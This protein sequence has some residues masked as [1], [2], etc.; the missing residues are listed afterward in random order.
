MGYV[1][2]EAEPIGPVRKLKDLCNS[3]GEWQLARSRS[4]AHNQHDIVGAFGVLDRAAPI[5]PV[6]KRPEPLKHKL[7]KKRRNSAKKR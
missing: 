6:R 7:F 2:D 1:L 3:R 5:G 4:S